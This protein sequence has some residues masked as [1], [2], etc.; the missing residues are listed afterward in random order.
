MHLW[1]YLVASVAMIDSHHVMYINE[2]DPSGSQLQNYD[3]ETLTL[4]DRLTRHNVTVRE[5]SQKN[6]HTIPYK[7]RDPQ[8]AR[9]FVSTLPLTDRCC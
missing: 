6:K 9:H 7:L 8:K 2:R 1:F 3:I 4:L 5:S